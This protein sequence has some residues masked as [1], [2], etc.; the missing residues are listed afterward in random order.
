MFGA[1]EQVEPFE[2]CQGVGK[3]NEDGS[4]GEPQSL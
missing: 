4:P 2:A 1:V 3:P